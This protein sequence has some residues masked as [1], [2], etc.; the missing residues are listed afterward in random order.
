M[1]N[2]QKLANQANRPEQE[3]VTIHHELMKEMT[4]QDRITRKGHATPMLA[5]VPT[6][7]V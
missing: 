1:I 2:A 7:S 5:Q 4:A 3:A 6:F